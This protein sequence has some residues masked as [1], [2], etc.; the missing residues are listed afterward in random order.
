LERI[1]TIVVET[2]CFDFIVP[3]VFTPANAGILGVNNVFYIKMEHMD[4]WSLIIFDRWGKEM[5]N[6]TN[7]D[8][9]WTGNT[10]GG[11]QVPAGVYYYIIS[12]ACQNTT[13]KKDGFV[14]LIR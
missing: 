5:F 1:V 13:Y 14:Q 11:G 12:A 9:Y 4:A 2:R 10:E 6:T 3:N 7:P 8:A